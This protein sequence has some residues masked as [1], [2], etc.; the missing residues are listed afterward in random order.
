MHG[1]HRYGRPAS[2]TKAA[3]DSTDIAPHGSM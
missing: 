3:S 1:T 2:S